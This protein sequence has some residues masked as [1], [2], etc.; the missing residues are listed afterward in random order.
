[1]IT[2]GYFLM[3][4]G[5]FALV[6]LL[7]GVTYGM[8]TEGLYALDIVKFFTALFV[9]GALNFGGNAVIDVF[10]PAEVVKEFKTN[11]MNSYTNDV[12]VLVNDVRLT[13]G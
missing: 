11:D 4:S 6:I 3:I 10:T 9:F 1:M 2:F 8:I 12:G 7:A 5:I 13:D